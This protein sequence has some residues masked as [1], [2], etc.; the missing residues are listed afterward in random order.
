MNHSSD[1]ALTKADFEKLSE[2]R[3]R[4]RRFLHVSETILREEGITPLQYLMLLHIKGMRG[5][6]W[7]T[8]GELAERLQALQHGVVTLVSRCEAAGF[9]E[10]RPCDADRRQVEVHLLPRGERC[11]DVLATRHRAQLDWFDDEWPLRLGTRL[12]GA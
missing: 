3:Y 5:R 7:A 9:V 4:L 1:Q 8:V 12:A 6:E 10:R 11:L 2:F